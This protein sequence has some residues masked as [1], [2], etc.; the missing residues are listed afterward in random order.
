[1]CH[2]KFL[3][4][5][6]F[7]DTIK[8]RLMEFGGGLPLSV[9]NILLKGARDIVKDIVRNLRYLVLR[10]YHILSVILSLDLICF[11]PS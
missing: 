10:N 2:K 7:L 11:K 4:N 9:S 5:F 1:M 8:Q 3:V 6:S